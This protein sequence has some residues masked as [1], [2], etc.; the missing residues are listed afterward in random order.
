MLTTPLYPYQKPFLDSFLE[1][2]HYLLAP[3]M[4]TGKTIIAIAG[5]ESLLGEGK[6]DNVLVVCPSGLKF[7]WA[8]EIA[9]HTDVT[10]YTRRM[11]SQTITIPT[12]DHCIIVDGDSDTRYT[13]LKQADVLRPEYIIVSY[14][15]IL[16]DYEYFTTAPFGL[17]ILDEASAIKNPASDRTKAVKSTLTSPYRLALTGTPVENKPEDVF[18][19]MEWVEPDHLGRWDIFDKSFITRNPWGQ[20]KRYKNMHVL[21]KKLAQVM[22]RITIDHPDVASHMPQ[23]SYEVALVGMY[24]SH[25]RVYDS[26]AIHLLEHMR[27]NPPAY[28]TFDVAARYSGKPDESTPDGRAMAMHQAMLMFCDHP[29]LVQASADAYR[30]TEG[31]HGSK[32]AHQIAEAGW[33]EGINDTCRKLDFVLEEVDTIL[34]DDSQAKILLFTQYRRMLDIFTESLAHWGHVVY[35]GEM[36]TKQKT[37]AQRQFETDP[38]TRILVSTHAGAYGLNLPAASVHIN[39][40]VAWAFGKQS[41][42]NRRA[43]R[44]SSR[45]ERVEVIDVIVCNTVEERKHDV[46]TQKGVTAAAVVD[47]VGY[48]GRDLGVDATA[49]GLM[50]H[51]EDYLNARLR[52]S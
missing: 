16:T 50:R 34:G 49:E 51:L 38:G 3:D 37:G 12:P 5:A 39:Y 46:M 45:H 15:T 26:L 31:K 27:E 1:L 14:E 47:G 25:R 10:T 22:G 23:R 18:S 21:S 42:I 52:K 13:L 40:D 44:A 43:V 2:G 33:L 6:I 35:H 24:V 20:P 32:F 11:G 7:Q 30:D 9:Q 17:T 41:Q 29:A 19:I 8:Q 28:G 4:G 48:A 36:T